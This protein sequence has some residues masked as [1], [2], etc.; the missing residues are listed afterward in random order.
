MLWG[1]GGPHK[2]CSR[3]A[4][5][6]W[7]L[8]CPPLRYVV[9]SHP[10]SN[11]YNVN[12]WFFMGTAIIIIIQVSHTYALVGCNRPEIFLQIL[13]QWIEWQVFHFLKG[14]IPWFSTIVIFTFSS[15]LRKVFVLF[16][17]FVLWGI[18]C[19]CKDKQVNPYLIIP[20][21]WLNCEIFV[22][23]YE[24]LSSLR[25]LMINFTLIYSKNTDFLWH[26]LF[27]VA[28]MWLSRIFPCFLTAKNLLF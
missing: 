11:W 16:F 22:E 27:W 7:A 20:H 3:T 17:V 1:P 18:Q 8:G 24:R 23:F 10:F 19:V 28:K 13:H 4:C 15:I 26:F 21:W 9:K 25:F 14:Q 5:G 6:P 2:N 12:I